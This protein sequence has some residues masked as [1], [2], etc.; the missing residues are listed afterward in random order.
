MFEPQPI[1]AA[2]AAHLQAELLLDAGREADAARKYEWIAHNA[3]DLAERNGALGFLELAKG[4]ASA[5]AN[6][7]AAAVQASTTDARIVFE[8]AMLLRES[9]AP[10]TR[11]RVTS[12][13]RDV[14]RMDAGFSEALFI[15][16]VRATDEGQ[17]AQAIEYLHQATESMPRQSSFWHAL[18][19]AEA[20]S[21]N[22]EQSRLSAQKA[23]RTA[24]DPQEHDMARALLGLQDE[25]PSQRNA[26]PA[27][28]VPRGWENPKGDTKTT[29]VLE[30]LDCTAMASV[31]K[32]LVRTSS[33]V[34]AFQMNNPR[35]IQILDGKDAF[36]EWN[37]G[38]LAPRR[39]EL[40][41]LRATHE[42]VVL[43]FLP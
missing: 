39:V 34:E 21:G 1:S 11:D 42:L 32:L 2:A 29:G 33:G 24:K 38:K 6:Y 17:Y 31:P 4:N 25:K 15:L 30:S 40:E 27:V 3:S 10:G 36:S 35:Q 23:L 41:Y 19:F 12:L 43:R 37:C 18:A 22:L 13:L 14:V 26:G 16:G 7:F 5:A 20:K 9:A 28:T 8:Y